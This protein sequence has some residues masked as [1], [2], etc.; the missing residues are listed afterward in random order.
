MKN[1]RRKLASRGSSATTSC[2][3]LPS[4]EDLPALEDGNTSASPPS[5]DGSPLSPE[6]E[7]E[8]DATILK[9]ME[10]PTAGEEALPAP[11]K[12]AVSEA[13]I[14]LVEAEERVWAD[15]EE[16]VV[17]DLVLDDFNA[18]DLLAEWG[19]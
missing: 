3:S 9:V 10:M 18:R 12:E 8:I 6:A 4:I 19:I 1:K 15:E 7:S 11:E 13:G 5:D 16:C 14:G 17:S 2:G